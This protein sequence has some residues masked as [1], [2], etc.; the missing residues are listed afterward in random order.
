ME[1]TN[2]MRLWRVT[3]TTGEYCMVTH[4]SY[5][6]IAPDADEA[7]SKAVAHAHMTEEDKYTVEVEED[8]DGIMRSTTSY[9]KKGARR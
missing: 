8:E 3:F 4:T 2:A 7:R 1:T 5:A 9:S 6:V